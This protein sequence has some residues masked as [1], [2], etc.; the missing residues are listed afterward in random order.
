MKISTGRWVSGNDFFDREIELKILSKLVRDGNHV[1]VTGQR[2]MGK[3]SVIQELGQ[4]LEAQGWTFF[5]TDAEAATCEEDVIADVAQAAQRIASSKSHHFSK[6]GSWFLG[7]IEEISVYRVKAKLRAGLTA[8][9]WRRHG[10]ELLRACA[11]QDKPILLVLDELPIFLKRMLRE[12]GESEGKQRVETF[13]SWLRQALQSINS[14]SLVVIVSGS[15]GLQPLVWRLGISDRINYL[16]PFRVGPWD[17]DTSVQCFHRLAETC[18]LQVE[19]G[20]AAAVYDKLGIGIPHHVQS[21]FARLYEYAM[22]GRDRVTVKDVELV[23]QNSLLG[24]PGQMDLRLYES[25]LEDGLGN[26]YT[27]AMEILAA[28]ALQEVFTPSSRRHLE[29]LFDDAPGRIAEVIDILVHDGY[30]TEGDDGHRFLSH[31]LKDWWAARFRGHY[32]PLEN[33]RPN[34]EL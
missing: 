14:R 11:A 4:R 34:N 20:V 1:L 27:I 22:Q 26:D 6:V 25:R 18:Q 7:S 5:F 21:F 2:R 13:L 30:L 23:Y 29:K 33:R 12:S 17:R 3:T 31:L 28:A 32:I 24:P 10:N 9:N 15:I 8:G 16:H 19:D